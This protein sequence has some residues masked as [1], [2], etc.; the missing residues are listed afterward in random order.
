MIGKV[1]SR[2]TGMATA[3]TM[4][5]RQSCKKRYVMTMTKISAMTSVS[6][7]SW[8]VVLMNLVGS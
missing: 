3:G 8:I 6:T 5:A 1:A 2:E 7:I 4:V